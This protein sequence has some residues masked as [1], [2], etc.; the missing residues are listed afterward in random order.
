[1][2]RVDRDGISLYYEASG[3]GEA[4]AFVNDVGYGAWAWGWQHDALAA[5]PYETLVW[6]PRGT[7]RSDAPEG[8]YAVGTLANDLDAVL[9]AAGIGGVHLVGAGLGGMVALDYAHD[10]R[11][12]ESLTL[13]GTAATG[14]RVDADALAALGAP[15]EDH[16]AL[17]ASLTGAFGPDVP[18]DH[19][20]LDR[21]AEWRAQ[22][23]ATPA[24]REAQAAAMLGFDAS[25][26]L[27]EVT[28]PALVVHGVEDAIVPAA[29]G[30]A[31]AEG[32]PRGEYV[33]VEAGHLCGVEASRAVSDEL[34]AFL[35]ESAGE[36]G[37][38]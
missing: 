23:D 34:L 32:L 16:E 13:L 31:L 37:S 36:A 2:P 22:D 30:E 21:I 38:P 26:W 35:A 27:Y 19:D 28:Q 14:D 18:A 15:L 9:S 20:L 8:P 33:P 6:D 5:A 1:M 10:A 17:R 24:A 25:D 12:V 29:A 7:G 11:R 4:V 3:G